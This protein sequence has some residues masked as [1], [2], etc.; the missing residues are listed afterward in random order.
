MKCINAILITTMLLLS[1]CYVYPGEVEVVPEVVFPITPFIPYYYSTPRGN[2][3][4][5]HYI[6]PNHPRPHHFGPMNR[7]SHR[8][9]MGPRGHFWHKH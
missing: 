8:M 9:P 1:G 6:H 4:H 7:P 5:H 2:Y 3:Y